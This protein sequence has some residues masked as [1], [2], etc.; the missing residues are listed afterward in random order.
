MDS[1]VG[2]HLH[3]SSE[4]Q[5]DAEGWFYN[6]NE[7]DEDS[8]TYEERTAE[9]VCELITCPSPADLANGSFP[10]KEYTYG[11]IV[12]YTCNEGFDIVKDGEVTCS[13]RSTTVKVRQIDVNMFV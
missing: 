6:Y 8:L 7:E 12:K 10:T 5:C 2:Y 13:G 1:I 4:A 9:P 3:G 11:E